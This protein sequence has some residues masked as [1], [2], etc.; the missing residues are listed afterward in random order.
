MVPITK[1]KSI[2]QANRRALLNMIRASGEVSV[3]GISERLKL[4]KPTVMKIISHYLENGLILSAGK[5][6]S[7]EEGGKKPILYKFNA[8]GG[9][10]VGFHVF[11]DEL[12]AVVS[13]LDA[14]ILHEKSFPFKENEALGKVVAAMSSAYGWLLGQDPDY[15]GKVI[16]IAVGAHGI[17]DFRR[18]VV[19]H[20]PHFPSWGENAP[21]AR[22]LKKELSFEGPVLV[23]NQI[24]F[25]VFA[26]KVKGVAKDKKNIIVL[27]GGVGLVAGVIVKDEIKR[28]AHFLAGEIGHMIINPEEREECACGG[29]GCFE[30]MVS[31]KRILRLAV[32]K[33]KKFREPTSLREI[34][35][36]AL[37]ILDIFKASNNGD[38]LAQEVVDEAAQWFAIGLSNLVLA[39]DPE[40]LVLQGI[41]AEAGD[42]FI[43]QLRRKINE[44]S[45]VH[46]K[47]NV[48]I[49]YSKFGR[50]A[51]VLGAAA[52]VIA[53]HLK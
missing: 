51:G 23:D 27:E 53:E 2:K 45:L 12:Y 28:G 30:T 9:Y 21:L 39:Y 33:I 6:A 38:T 17:T 25:Q 37:T 20:S 46:I 19:I 47:K 49:E 3:A 1:P 26:E 31:V 41:F 42:Y 13:D 35:P 8:R 24:R 50:N 34:E 15:A 52:F 5:G 40:I 14:A 16:G 32:E 48:Q 10:V 22:L 43:R 36:C 29:R 7:T 11:P 18:G 44:V 4:S